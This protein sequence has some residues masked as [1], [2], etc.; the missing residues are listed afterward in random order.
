M[1][2]GD[3]NYIEDIVNAVQ[4]ADSDMVMKVYKRLYSQSP[5]S[6]DLLSEHSCNEGCHPAQYGSEGGQACS[7]GT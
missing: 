1:A 6:H 2:E 3:K 5:M 7:S 4:G